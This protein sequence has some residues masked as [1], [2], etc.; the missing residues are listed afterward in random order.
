MQIAHVKEEHTY[1][2]KRRKK[3]E[4]KQTQT[5]PSVIA[6]F[7]CVVP[8]TAATG[9]VAPCEAAGVV[10]PCEAAG[11][12]GVAVE[13]QYDTLKGLIRLKIRSTNEI[14]STFSGELGEDRASGESVPPAVVHC[15]FIS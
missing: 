14:D 15:C 2:Y 9:V 5:V 8:P 7:S 12:V 4:K 1:T 3:K 10:A 13:E 6:L 11:A